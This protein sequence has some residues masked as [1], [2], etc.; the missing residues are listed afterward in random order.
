MEDFKTCSLETRVNVFY[1]LLVNLLRGSP[2]RQLDI[3]QWPEFTS[4]PPQ[5][6]AKLLRLMASKA[7]VYGG[8]HNYIADWLRH[9]QELCPGDRR[10]LLLSAIYRTSPSLCKLLLR[11][12]SMRQIDARDI[13]PFADLGPAFS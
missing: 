5:H 8:D 7:I 9:A 13:P 10:G 12:R 3:I 1:D 11:A 6:Q 2:S 4:L